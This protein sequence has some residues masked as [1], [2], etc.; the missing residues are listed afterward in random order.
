MLKVWPFKLRKISEGAE[1]LAN[2]SA[3]GKSKIYV[4]KN[5]EKQKVYYV[6]KQ[7]ADASGV[8]N[9]KEETYTPYTCR[10]SWSKDQSTFD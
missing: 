7:A 9:L 2:I 3:L 8:A 6:G 5:A 1:V 4:G 10:K